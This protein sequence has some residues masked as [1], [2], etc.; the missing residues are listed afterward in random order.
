[1]P[2]SAENVFLFFL[3]FL[4]TSTSISFFATL[5]IEAPFSFF[6]LLNQEIHVVCTGIILLYSSTYI[7][8]SV[9]LVCLLSNPSVSLLHELSLLS[10][11]REARYI[12]WK[13]SKIG[14][15]RKERKKVWRSYE[16][17]PLIYVHTVHR[18]EYITAAA[19]SAVQDDSKGQ[20]MY[21]YIEKETAAFAPCFSYKYIVKLFFSCSFCDLAVKLHLLWKEERK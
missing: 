7:H 14:K 20:R 4:S 17:H 2:H 12:T 15:E 16:G 21:T 1:M 3:W 18:E 5:T 19:F 10:N 13:E 9:G 6:E 8:S 11:E